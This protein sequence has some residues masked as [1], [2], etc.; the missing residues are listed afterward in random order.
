MPHPVHSTGD[1]IANET[2]LFSA[3]TEL[4]KKMPIKQVSMI[5]GVKG[6]DRGALG[7]SRSGS[8]GMGLE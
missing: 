4:S 2:S 3:L 5:K 1:S 7:R 6:W 8:L